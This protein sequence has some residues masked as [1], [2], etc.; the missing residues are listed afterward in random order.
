MKKE[1]SL[2]RGKVLMN[3][4]A[5]YC[6]T[7]DRLLSSDGFKRVLI[8]YFDYVKRR[9]TENYTVIMKLYK[10]W[11]VEDAAADFTG[12]LKLLTMLNVDE[13]KKLQ[14]RYTVLLEDTE[15]FV[16]LLEDFYG[17]W[18][19]LERYSVV[20]SRFSV[21]GLAP[22][23]F[24]NANIK[25]NNL[26]LELY[27][28]VEKNVKMVEGNV[29]RQVAA[30]ANAGLVLTDARWPMPGGY[31]LLED[32]PFISSI[33]MESPFITYPKRNKRDGIF[34]EVHEHPIDKAY[35]NKDHFY[36]YPAKVGELLAY[37]YF[38]RDLMSH[39][40][41]LSNLFEMARVEEYQGR[42]PDLVYMYGAKSEDE[43]VGNVFYDDKDNGI[44]FGFVPFSEKIDYFGY[45]KKM[46]LTLHNLVMIKRGFLPIHGAMVHIKLKNGKSAN[47]V[48]VGDSGAG[49]SE[50]LEALRSLSEEHI[51]DMTIIFDDMGSFKLED[52]K[53]VA[54]GT[55][56]GAFVR[57]DDLDQGYAFKEIDRSIFMNPD[58]TNARLV[59][60]V[61]SY[62]DV[63]RG[64]PVDIFLYANNFRVLCEGDEAI[65]YFENPETAKAVFRA[66]RRMAKGTTTENG[67]V[68]SYFANPFGPVQKQKENDK[69]MD[70]FFEELFQRGVKVGEIYT[71]LGVEG[72]ENDGPRH[73]SIELFEAIT[74]LKR[75]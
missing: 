69:L 73:A 20:V 22:T 56:I 35:I 43:T 47:V 53:V 70:I 28:R 36:C 64:Y 63:V 74:Q 32:I 30:G 1:F 46:V 9:N 68:D 2:S 72:M 50:S 17:Y 57:L 38:H 51:S 15:E 27:R 44:M 11:E 25:F 52:G 65:E 40:I 45:M 23:G 3:F 14:S 21:E 66:G 62:S 29:Y 39:G 19:K 12:L 49:K 58:K 61:S 59:M 71:Q 6:D 16:R 48:I 34:E 13:V 67:I 24:I 10:D 31:E 4:S 8:S 33:V 42:K 26:I 41:S 54:Y 37:I 55:E 18:R 7:S 75:S 5:K 60:P